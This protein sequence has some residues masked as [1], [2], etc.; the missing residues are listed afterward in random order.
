MSYTTPSKSLLSFI[1]DSDFKIFFNAFQKSKAPNSEIVDGNTAKDVLLRSNL[2]AQSLYKIWTLADIG[3][4][5][6]LNLLE[7]ALALY[8]AKNAMNNSPIPDSLPTAISQ[9]MITKS[10][11]TNFGAISTSS[12][13][14]ENSFIGGFSHL[15]VSSSL[16]SQIPSQTPGISSHKVEF[17]TAVHSDLSSMPIIPNP[18]SSIPPTDESVDKLASDFA[19]RFPDIGADNNLV[20]TSPKPSSTSAVNSNNIISKTINWSISD[21]EKIYYG[22]QFR[23]LDTSNSGSLSG[24]VVRDYFLKFGLPVNELSKIWQ[25]S[26]SNGSGVLNLA[27]FSVALH[28][29]NKRKNN[30]P[31]PP[32]LPHELVDFINSP[33]LQKTSIESQIKPVN[34]N[35]S[36]AVQSPSPLSYSSSI[37]KVKKYN[38]DSE[39]LKSSRRYLTTEKSSYNYSSQDSLTKSNQISELNSYL[40]KKEAELEKLKRSNDNILHSQ[41][42]NQLPSEIFDKIYSVAEGTLNLADLSSDETTISGSSGSNLESLLIKR[43]Q[44]ATRSYLVY[45]ELQRMFEDYSINSKKYIY[46]Q[47]QKIKEASKATSPSLDDK[48]SKAASLIAQRMKELTGMTYNFEGSPT[49]SQGPPNLNLDEF[50]STVNSNTTRYNGF[51]AQADSIF[52]QL[53]MGGLFSINELGYLFDLNSFEEFCN[54]SSFS[55]REVSDLV[56][57][58]NTVKILPF[59][60]KELIP[61]IVLDFIAPNNKN[62]SYSSYNGFKSSPFVAGSPSQQPF[63]SIT[64]GSNLAPGISNSSTNSLGNPINT[65]VDSRNSGTKYSQSN[66]EDRAARLKKLAEQRLLERQR[67]LG[68]S[69]EDPSSNSPFYDSN[70]KSEKHPISQPVSPF[71]LSSNINHE[72]FDVSQNTSSEI[73]ANQADLLTNKSP[74]LPQPPQPTSQSANPFFSSNEKVHT[75]ELKESF[76]KLHNIPFSENLN[77]EK[78][79]GNNQFQNTAATLFSKL[80]GTQN[81]VEKDSKGGTNFFDDDNGLSSDSSSD[82]FESQ[83]QSKPESKNLDTQDPG[84]DYHQK[85]QSPFNHDPPQNISDSFDNIFNTNKTT[86]NTFENNIEP[87]FYQAVFDYNS[88]ESSSLSLSH[89]DLMIVLPTPSGIVDSPINGKFD[90]NW[91]YGEKIVLK[92]LSDNV[93]VSKDYDGWVLSGIRGWIPKIYVSK[94]GGLLSPSWSKFSAVYKRI[95]TGYNSRTPE[96]V[97]VVS[98]QTVRI[99]PNDDDDDDSSDSDS[100]FNFDNLNDK[101]KYSSSNSG[102]TKVVFV[103]SATNNS[104]KIGFI[105]SSCIQDYP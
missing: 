48:S 89:K 92:E 56:N 72:I 25:L 2:P 33:S 65:S 27:E 71:N 80:Y 30:E 16:Q 104:A 18:Q 41:S 21:S 103:D 9:E 19:A 7:F 100:S 24:A 12:A 43:Q 40:S 10:N 102:F 86:G 23:A 55:N 99:L 53:E 26:D 44:L 28:L 31:I 75:P 101:I 36:S 59:S 91:I 60:S 74:F 45:A 97:T 38:D 49:P 15:G 57:R 68:L 95:A 58:L 96:E 73:A 90:S 66:A 29:L 13:S 69:I 87:L 11:S 94:I 85:S 63:N 39:I 82:F 6:Y 37:P 17:P 20:Y 22:D 84:L 70:E 1:S 51:I 32:T 3:S 54:S 105:P 79:S 47:E 93:N 46:D 5:G 64:T 4:K 35:I 61:E 34:N 14:A 67:A 50:E 77:K 88:N 42:K 8:L 76:E 98:G 83:S 52:H 78:D 62:S 81:E